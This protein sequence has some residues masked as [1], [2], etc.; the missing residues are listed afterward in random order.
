MDS[1]DDLPWKSVARPSETVFEGDDGILELE[2]VENVEVYYE[3]TAAG[4]V[5]KFKVTRLLCICGLTALR[6][7]NT[8]SRAFNCTTRDCGIE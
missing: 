4:R 2:E 6:T 7:V 8:D 5:A 1:I 3:E